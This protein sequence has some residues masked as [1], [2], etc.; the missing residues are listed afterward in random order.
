MKT[1]FRQWLLREPF[2]HFLALGALIVFVSNH[3]DPDRDRYR[4]VVGAD[5]VRRLSNGYE[6]QYGAAPAAAQLQ[7]LIDH[8]I[9]E[10][11]LYRE[12]AALDLAQQDQIVRRRVAQKFE[13][14][15][16][17]AAADT[18]PSNAALAQYYED[19]RAQY[20][21]PATVALTHVYFSA[22]RLSDQSRKLAADALLQLR[23]SGAARA[24]SVG[25]RFAGLYDFSA[26]NKAD[27]ARVFG[28]SEIVEL[29]FTAAPGRWVGPV[30][31]AYGWHLLRVTARE[32]GGAAPLSQVRDRVAADYADQR[33]RA[34]TAAAFARLRARYTIVRGDDSRA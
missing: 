33:R 1:F 15:Q 34:R 27:L 9:R 21:Q 10:E 6:K 18:P 26:L 2:V 14:L 25:D 12:G 30:R 32:E 4:I 3:W 17:D 29:A 5:V 7:S 31:S 16:L 13:Y 11:I 24:P 20:R 19:N 23:A 22:D 8:H 28:D